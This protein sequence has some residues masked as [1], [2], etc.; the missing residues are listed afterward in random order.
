MP[1]ICSWL[2]PSHQE[3]AIC[4]F[5]GAGKELQVVL[6]ISF[7]ELAAGRAF[8]QAS[9][10]IDADGKQPGV[11]SQE[12]YSDVPRFITKKIYFNRRH[13]VSRSGRPATPR[14]AS[15]LSAGISGS[16]NV[17]AAGPLTGCEFVLPHGDLVANRIVPN[18]TSAAIIAGVCSKALRCQPDRPLSQ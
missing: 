16:L 10:I 15:R 1:S 6:P 13:R 2:P 17:R 12:P 3:P 11:V 8:Q 18:I 7:F 14:S 5:Q 4:A 9:S